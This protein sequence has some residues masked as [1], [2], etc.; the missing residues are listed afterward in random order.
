MLSKALTRSG[1]ALALTG[2]LASSAVADTFTLRDKKQVT[3]DVIELTEKAVRIRTA[4]NELVLLGFEK[5]APDSL[6]GLLRGR[7][8][9]KDAKARL[10]LS[11]TCKRWKA[12]DGARSELEA[13]VKLDP[14]LAK[15]A[16][17]K[18]KSIDETQAGELWD[19]ALELMLAK[20]HAEALAVFR[21]IADRFAE[22]SFAEKALAKSVEAV[23]G[24]EAADAAV[25]NNRPGAQQKK[26]KKKLTRAEKKAA[27]KAAQIKYAQ[28]QADKFQKLADEQ[29]RAA[30]GFDGKGQI[31]KAKR[32]YEAALKYDLTA[33][34]FLG[35]TAG[36][37]R[38]ATDLATLEKAQ[39][40]IEKLNK[41][42][43]AVHLSLS[44]LH[45][46]ER[47]FKRARTHVT[48]ALRLDPMN[49]RAL[50]MREEIAKHSINRKASDLTNA[51]GR[52]TSGR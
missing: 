21:T 19:R 23:K 17:A 6:Y 48:T 26:K 9:A 11:D 4:T 50:E 5:L 43:V 35:K 1:I 27:K 13:A 28:E 38:V 37:Q 49:K 41:H 33:K 29:N 25:E 7:V 40:Q 52:V 16:A 22:T 15:T 45:M 10:E 8:D 31:S 3:G 39:K 36:V 32:S 2:L 42:I 24:L 20:K 34:E 12:Y 44:A 46:K 18:R 47:N 30:F 14:K 51:K